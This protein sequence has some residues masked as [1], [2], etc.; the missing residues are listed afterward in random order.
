MLDS[1]LRELSIPHA[2]ASSPLTG[3]AASGL[4]GGGRAPPPHRAL[5]AA[6]SAVPSTPDL[7]KAAQQSYQAWLGFYNGSLRALR[8]G[9]TG[10]GSRV[11]SWGVVRT[12][13]GWAFTA[14]SLRAP[15]LALGLG[16]S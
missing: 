6:L 3:G 4:A 15:R 12:G 1:E 8:Y 16:V 10:S 7:L 9:V 5:A 13:H 14:A 2:S 11:P